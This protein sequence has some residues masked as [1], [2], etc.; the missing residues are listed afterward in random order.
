MRTDPI[1]LSQGAPKTMSAPL[2][3]R[4]EINMEGMLLNFYFDTRAKAIT[5]Q[6]VVATNYNGQGVVWY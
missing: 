5:S 3:G 2:K 6:E 4:I 1:D